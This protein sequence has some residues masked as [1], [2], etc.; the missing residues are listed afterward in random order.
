MNRRLG[1]TEAIYYLLDS[2]HCLNF[3]VFAEV[4]GTLERANLDRALRVA[5]QE[6]PVL[7]ARIAQV[8]GHPAF[9]AVSIEQAP[10]KA[11]VV[12][13]RNW[14]LRLAEQL[15]TPFADAAPLARFLWF[16]GR[17][18]RSVAA[19]VFHHAIADGRSGAQ[20][21]LDVLRRA[22][23]EDLPV[24]LQAARPSAQDL[25]PINSKGMVESTVQKMGFWLEQGRATLKF[26]CQL[27][28]YDPQLRSRRSIKAI[29]Y[30]LSPNKGQALLDACRAHGTTVHGVLGAA[31]ILAINRE[32]GAPEKRHLALT[33]LADLRGVLSDQLSADDL[34]LYIAT[35]TTVHAVAARPDLWQL[36]KDLKSQLSQLLHSGDANL[37]HAFYPRASLLP[38]SRHSARLVQAAAA[39]GPPASMLTNI[40][41]QPPLTLRNGARVRSLAFM[42]SP[43]PQHPLCVTVAGYA[44]GLHLHLLY[45]QTKLGNEQA[46][47]I[48]RTLIGFI[49]AA[50]DESHPPEKP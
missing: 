23:G 33:S 14:R 40:G 47:R 48:G 4:G 12:Q 3:V 49:E 1:S 37:I 10:L 29:S 2:L 27:P 41:N 45:D 22:G 28:G 11:Q 31:Q 30:T 13:L 36:A 17:A 26:P 44:G 21:L 32:C 35:L 20:V 38:T 16:G 24:A 7:R 46:Q 39:L 9:E 5:Q 18:G 50:I 19:M 42:V 6:K 15:D 8:G 43:P 34:G 25:D